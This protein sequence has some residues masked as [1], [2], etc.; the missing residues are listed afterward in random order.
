MKIDENGEHV[1]NSTFNKLDNDIPHSLVETPD[2]GFLLLGETYETPGG[3][4]D[5]WIIRTDSS[6]NHLWNKTFGYSSFDD[7][8][9]SI[10]ACSGGGYALTGETEGSGSGNADA[11]LVRIDE[12]GNQL[13]NQSHGGADEHFPADVVELSDGGFALCL[14]AKVYILASRI[15]KINQYQ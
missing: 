2:G 10:I 4:Q 13:W 7:E 1:W 6:G 12:S 5:F 3:N 11:W 8:G 15:S 9:K 14:L